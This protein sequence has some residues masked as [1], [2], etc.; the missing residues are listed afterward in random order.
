MVHN[1]ILEPELYNVQEPFVNIPEDLIRDALKLVLGMVTLQFPNC[2]L[3]FLLFF[4]LA[5]FLSLAL[6]FSCRCTESST[7]H[8]LQKGEGTNYNIIISLLYSPIIDP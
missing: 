6:E 4:S 7:S 1:F 2:R 5:M 8:S 3:T